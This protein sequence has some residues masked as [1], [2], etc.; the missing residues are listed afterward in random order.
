MK[1][2]ICGVKG[3]NSTP[4]RKIFKNQAAME[5]WIEKNDG[6]VEVHGY[7]EVSDTHPTDACFE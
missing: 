3:M 5:K 6:D 4:F 1:I 7:R 2:E